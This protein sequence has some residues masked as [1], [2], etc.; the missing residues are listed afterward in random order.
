MLIDLSVDPELAELRSVV[1]DFL[2]TRLLPIEGA[3]ER[4]GELPDQ[5]WAEVEQ[6]GRDLGFHA[7]GIPQ[8]K[9]GGGLGIVGQVLIAEEMGHV[10]VGFR[11]VIGTPAGSQAIAR[12]GTSEQIGKYLTPW[13]AGKRW[14]AWAATEPDAGSDLGGM[15]TAAVPDGDG[16]RIN[17]AKHFI[18]SV[19]RADFLIV[20]AK[21]SPERGIRGMTAYFVDKDAPGVMIGPEQA[22]MGR[23]GL[24]S[25]PVY[26]Q[27]VLVSDDAR[28]G[29]VNSGI[30]VLMSNVGELRLLV[31]AHCVGV[32]TRLVRIARDWGAKREQ[33]GVAIR[34]FGQLQGYL[35]D[36]VPR[37]LACRVAVL[38]AADRIA[39]GAGVREET[40][41]VKAQCAELAFDVADRVMQFL[42]GYGYSKDMPVEALFRA[43]RLWQ[44]AEGSSE[45]QRLLIWRAL[46]SGWSPSIDAGAE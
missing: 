28:L 17:G 29:E 21:T 37:L 30:Q 24:H 26:L 35:A 15:R 42:G 20:F 3:L 9:G 11:H 10:S 23:G 14:G 16:W 36:I 41:I 4:D 39:Q 7:L 43:T 13:L 27:D 32:A 46:D 40:A 44:I 31:A 2:K 22:M 33:F 34:E 8:D 6:A 1:R 25:Y 38:H 12:F 45:I 19:D 5:I 18:T